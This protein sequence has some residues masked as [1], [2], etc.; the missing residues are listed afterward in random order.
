MF[1][2]GGVTFSEMRSAYEVSETGKNWEVVIGMLAKILLSSII[3]EKINIFTRFFQDR[4]MSL[5]QN[6]S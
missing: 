4:L 6:L 3:S 1:I 2:V 5:C